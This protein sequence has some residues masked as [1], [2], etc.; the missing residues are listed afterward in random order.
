MLDK[1]GHLRRES[2]RGRQHSCLIAFWTPLFALVTACG[3]IADAQFSVY[4][5]AGTGYHQDPL[6]NYEKI[7][8][9]VRQGYLDLSYDSEHP[10]SVFGLHYVGGLVVFNRLEDRNFYEHIFLGTYKIRLVRDRTSPLAPQDTTDA[11]GES[12]EDKLSASEAQAIASFRDSTGSFIGLNAKIAARHD[13]LLLRDFDN[14]SCELSANYRFSLGDQS[15][16]RLTNTFAGRSYSYVSELSNL[17]DLATVEIG[18]WPDSSFVYGA[19]GSV[20]YK[21]Y[22]SSLYDTTKFET[23]RGFSQNAPGKGK[24]G[25]KQLVAS[26]KDIL[27]VPQSNGTVEVVGG[28]F[29]RKDW[30]GNSSFLSSI[31]YRWMPR[32]AVRYLAQHSSTSLMTQDIYN[33]FFSY[34]GPEAKLYAVTR[35]FFNIQFTLEAGC[36]YRRYEAPALTLAGTEIGKNRSDM[37]S[38]A[39]ISLSRF[40]T[41][42]GDFGCDLTW[43]TELTRNQSNDDYNDFSFYAVTVAVGISF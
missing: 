12:G 2:K 30:S 6:Y 32:P 23:Q 9:Q 39:E 28:F 16:T 11:E 15:Y 7:S 10:S 13:K 5:S 14:Q 19:I 27:V 8:D 37:R 24:T 42:S 29:L 36:Q 4:A 35:L 17:N 38:S 40:F 43:M 25:G 33:D 1:K 3:S 34:Q 21:Y 18:W 26:V 31:L 20:G 22:T 41:L